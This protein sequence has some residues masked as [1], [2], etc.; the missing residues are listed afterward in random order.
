VQKSQNESPKQQSDYEKKKANFITRALWTFVMIGVFFLALFSGH[1][2]IM[3][4]ITVIQIISF[5]EVIAIASVP[6]RARQLNAT[7]SLNW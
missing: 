4:I 7:K 5:K 2:Y 3:L 6:S 1:I